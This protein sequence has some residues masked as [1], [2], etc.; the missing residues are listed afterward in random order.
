M[1]TVHDHRL[2]KHV[3]WLVYWLMPSGGME[4]K[5]IYQ[6]CSWPSSPSFCTWLSISQRQQVAFCATCP[7]LDWR[8]I[9]MPEKDMNPSASCLP[10]VY[11]TYAYHM[12]EMSDPMPSDSV[13]QISSASIVYL[14]VWFK[15][16]EPM[17]NGHTETSSHCTV[18]WKSYLIAI[19]LEIVCIIWWQ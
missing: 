13:A 5:T 8:L 10:W 12:H 9:V 7:T 14:V 6:L 19:W 1:P 4:L 11:H 3:A 15:T 17:L 16:S 18:T 2:L